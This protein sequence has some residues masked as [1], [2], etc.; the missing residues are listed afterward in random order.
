MPRDSF[1]A[2]LTEVTFLDPFQMRQFQCR[3]IVIS[4][5]EMSILAGMVA[6]GDEPRG[7]LNLFALAGLHNFQGANLRTEDI[8]CDRL[9][10]LCF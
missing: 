10:N 5:V 8:S 6:V 3:K 9:L 2:D 1:N 4:V 7:I